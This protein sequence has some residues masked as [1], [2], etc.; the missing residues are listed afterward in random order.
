ARSRSRGRRFVRAYCRSPSCSTRR[1]TFLTGRRSYVTGVYE[2]TTHFRRHLPQI[3]T[4]PQFF[5]E[6]GYFVAR[7]GK[8]FHAGV[9]GQIGQSGL[10]D[11]LSW[12]EVVNPRGRDKDEQS[13]VFTVN[14][15]PGI[16]YGTALGWLAANGSDPEQTDGQGASAAI[17][18]LEAHAHDPFFLA[19]GFYRPH[20]PFIVPKQ[21]IAQYSLESI[22]VPRDTGREGIP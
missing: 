13:Q 20:P 21:Y 2:N 8:V 3:V 1:A 7:V 11:P 5:K 9:P 19:V 6:H 16:G 15:G 12:H 22:E 17:T 10:D 4:L 14:A 18:L